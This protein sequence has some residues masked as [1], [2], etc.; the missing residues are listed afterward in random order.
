MSDPRD[1]RGMAE[2]WLRETPEGGRILDELGRLLAALK[3]EAEANDIETRS[4][5]Q[6]DALKAGQALDAATG[7]T[8]LR[9][10]RMAASAQ[11]LP[12]GSKADAADLDRLAGPDELQARAGRNAAR[13]ALARFTIDTQ[14]TTG[15]LGRLLAAHLRGADAGHAGVLIEREHR[16]GSDPDGDPAAMLKEAVVLSA[17]YTCGVE[18]NGDRIPHSLWGRAAEVHA[19]MARG[20]ALRG[21]S[22]KPLAAKTLKLSAQ[23]ARPMKVLFVEAWEQGRADRKAGIV[24]ANGDFRTLDALLRRFVSVD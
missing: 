1:F 12:V 22:V 3:R 8:G 19:A 6:A 16:Q 23:E 15:A 9:R 4:R 21:L 7:M 10:R 13:L 18:L 11:D 14:G 24:N 20:L 17:G 2:T 5:A